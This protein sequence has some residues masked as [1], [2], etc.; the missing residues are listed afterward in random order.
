MMWGWGFWGERCDESVVRVWVSFF[1]KG[2]E[3]SICY[4]GVWGRKR[5]V[6]KLQNRQEE[7][8]YGLIFAT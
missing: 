1:L 2:K 3:N 7:C 5:L 4:E 8:K 6:Y